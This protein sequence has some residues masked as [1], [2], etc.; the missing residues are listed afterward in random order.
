MRGKTGVLLVNLGTPDSTKVSDVRKYLRQFLLDGRVIDISPIG[1]FFLVNFII[2][3]F[4]SPKSAKEY[5]KLWTEKGSPLLY[6][7]VELTDLLREELDQS[8]FQVELGM[9]YQNPSIQSA[10]DKLKGPKLEKLIVLPLF[11]QYASATTGSVHQEVMRIVSKWELIP[12]IVMI[13]TYADN[14]LMAQTFAEL[15]KQYMVKEDYD[16]YLFSYHGLPERQLKKTGTGCRC[17]EKCCAVF[18]V[19]N[20]LCYRAQCYET[21]RVLA[22]ALNITEDQYTV[23]FQ[24]RLGK[25]PWIQP[26]TED[27]VKELAHKGIKK[28]LVFSP[29]FVAD[30]LETTVEINEEYGEQFLEEGGEKLQL[31]ESLNTHPMWVQTLKEMVLE[32]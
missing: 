28:L 3:P 6:H 27:K 1:R 12:K 23:S 22:R 2:A 11:P 16:H 29:S 13:D 18:S 21:S 17:D 14:E 19:R 24:S 26:Y 7:S 30:C 20:R 10:L 31:V 32:Q 4:R 15:G 25:T 9:R 8:A 5:R